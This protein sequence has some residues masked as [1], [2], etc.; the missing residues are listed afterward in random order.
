[1]DLVRY[2][3]FLKHLVWP[4]LTLTTAGAVAG[5]TA[6]WTP[7]A[8]ALLLAGLALIG[9]GLYF[10]GAITGSFWQRRSTQASTNALIATVALV[11]ILAMG[12]FLA[13][14]YLGRLDLTEN[15]IFTLA[16]QTQTLVQQLSQPVEIVVFDSTR[17]PQ[18]EQLLT[19]YRRQNPD[20]FS[21]EYIDPVSDPVT[22]QSFG[23]QTQGEVYLVMGDKRQLVQRVSPEERLSERRL[24]N[25]LDQ[26]TRDRDTVIYFLQGHGEYAIDGSEPGLFNAVTALED[27]NYT[28]RPLNFDQGA[29]DDTFGLF[30]ESPPD[31]FADGEIGED[32]ESAPLENPDAPDAPDDLGETPENAEAANP[33]L[34]AAEDGPKVPDDARMVI[35]AGPQQALFESEAKA[36]EDFLDRGGNAMILVDPNSEAGVASVLAGWGITLGGGLVIDTSGS[37]QLIGLGPAA[38]LVTRYGN[39]PITQDFDNG[40][41][42]FPVVQSITADTVPGITTEPLLFTAE[43]SQ[44]GTITESGDLEFDPA[45]AEQGPFAVGYA[46]SR[47]VTDEIIATPAP[48]DILPEDVPSEAAEDAPAPEAPESEAPE[49]DANVEPSTEVA[50]ADADDSP[51]IS[52]SSELDAGE[53]ASNPEEEAEESIDEE[54]V[55][56]EVTGEEV[57]GEE[58]TGN[59]EESESSSEAPLDAA[60]PENEA[61]TPGSGDEEIAE[62][63]LESRLVVI[64]NSTFATDGYFDQQLNGDVFINAVTWL[65]EDADAT[66]SIAPKETINRRIL[67]T[68]QQQISLLVFSLLVLPL[69]GIVGAIA[70]WLRRR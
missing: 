47:E 58:V 69:V 38:P 19:S 57:T 16:P 18:D 2:G 43:Q 65:E 33:D 55:D 15:Q 17:S 39:H 24:T 5:I 41:S 42:F 53:T 23:V 7:L 35:L 56:E 37:G 20:S 34:D 49:S 63:T 9:A 27:K 44:I 70:M 21:F 32:P 52:E 29:T 68:P 4:G 28:V 25:E 13:V 46:L 54:V 48:E 6:G 64:G 66:L 67:M 50:E 36:L 11:V 30:E 61:D 22:A 8:A 26:I 1:M 51:E 62:E 31:E 14:R 3:K 60:E 45:T 12:N 10:S 40:R 59:V